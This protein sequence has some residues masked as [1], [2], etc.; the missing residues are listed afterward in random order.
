MYSAQDV[1]PIGGADVVYFASMV[2]LGNYLALNLL[3]AVLKTEL[4]RATA[5]QRLKM[6][7]V[8][9][10][11]RRSNPGPPHMLEELRP[12]AFTTELRADGRAAA[13]CA[14]RAAAICA[15]HQPLT[16][17]TWCTAQCSTHAAS[18]AGAYQR[19]S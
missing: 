18:S 2:L 3:V 7:E 9:R 8:T 11:A 15:P 5:I 6:M 10:R 14:G 12:A 17:G 13:I 4:S 16:P 19:R 1:S